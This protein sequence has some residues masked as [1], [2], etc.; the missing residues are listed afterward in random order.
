MSNV[1]SFND[2]SYRI[3]YSWYYILITSEVLYITK[4][5]FKK[6]FL[7]SARQA[8]SIMITL[9]AVIY[10]FFMERVKPANA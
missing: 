10:T 8:N 1:Y 7:H 5:T 4:N 2:V 6:H 9:L 3:I